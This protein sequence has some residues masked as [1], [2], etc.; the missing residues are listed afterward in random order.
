MIGAYSVYENDHFEYELGLAQ[1][2]VHKPARVQSGNPTYYYS[3]FKRKDGGE[4]FFAMSREQVESYAK[5]HSKGYSNSR[6]VWQSH[7][8]SMAK[9]TVIIIGSQYTQKSAELNNIFTI[10]NK[11]E[12]DI[13][14]D[15]PSAEV[16]KKELAHA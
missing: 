16:V 2:L 3:I 7:F 15:A 12:A 8:D 9:K 14:L 11:D 1:R 4:S 5:K 10:D 6:G 13:T